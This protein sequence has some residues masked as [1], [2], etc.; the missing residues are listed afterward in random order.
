MYGSKLSEVHSLILSKPHCTTYEQ[1]SKSNDNPPDMLSRQ[2]VAITFYLP[3]TD[4]NLK[5]GVL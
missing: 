3:I 4:A 2:V 5:E 1:G